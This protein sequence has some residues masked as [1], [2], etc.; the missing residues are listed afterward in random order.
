MQDDVVRHL[1]NYRTACIY[2][3]CV[4]KHVTSLRRV[5][6]FRPKQ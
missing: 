5:L 4:E 2:Y 6:Q 3:T 1:A